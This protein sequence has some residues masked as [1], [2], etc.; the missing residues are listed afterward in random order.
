MVPHRCIIC[1]E[2]FWPF[3]ALFGPMIFSCLFAV[4]TF[5]KAA[6]WLKQS[7]FK[8]LVARIKTPLWILP[9][10]E[11]GALQGFS[12]FY[13]W[14]KPKRMGRSLECWLGL[15][16]LRV[17][18][19]YPRTPA[20]SSCDKQGCSAEWKW[21]FKNIRMALNPWHDKASTWGREKN[22]SVAM[23][24]WKHLLARDKEKERERGL[25]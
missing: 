14:K 24:G 3:P 9:R 22:L 1:G 2:L 10:G 18:G 5:W 20:S 15:M 25:E 21:S 7:I 16:G 4:L 12:Q 6:V 23:R 17:P 11:S 8:A 19:V 13:L